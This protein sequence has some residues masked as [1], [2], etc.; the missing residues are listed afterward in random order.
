[1]SAPP[2]RRTKAPSELDCAA[3]PL[4]CA[5]LSGAALARDDARRLAQVLKALADPARLQVI[6]LIRAAP[7]GEV[8][9]AD[10]V[11]ELDLSQ[12]TVSHHLR[13]LHDAGLL[14]RERRG[15]WVWYAVSDERVEEIRRLLG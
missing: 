1:M 13:V 3:D 8:C 12:P 6:S 7:G 5:P 2:L 10:L 9:V 4:C 11:R 15:S 14:R